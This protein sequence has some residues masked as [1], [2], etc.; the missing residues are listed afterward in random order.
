VNEHRERLLATLPATERRVDCAGISTPVL[1]GGDGPPVVLL[2]GPFGSSPHWMRVI[3]DLAITNRVIAPD[4]PG[5]G[6]SEVGDVALDPER[7][8]QWLDELIDRTCDSAPALVGHALGGGIA[9]RYASAHGDRLDRLVL[10]DSMGLAAFEPDPDFGV[11]LNEFLAEPTEST[12]DTLWQ[13]CALDLDTVR[14]RMGARWELFQAYNLDRA[15]TPSVKA[16]AGALMGV[17]GLP[18]IPADE[19][20]RIAVP[21]TLIWGRHDLAGPLALAEEASTRY[22]WPLHVIEACADDPP[23]EQPEAFTY[24]LRAAFGAHLLEARR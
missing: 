5:H 9:A 7:V 15:R 12:Y 14:D 11:A 1:E 17:F 24:A 20:E 23:I 22:G 18:A 2:H 4:L 13:H 21:T 6:E 3:P 16:A 10:V 19:L 8:L